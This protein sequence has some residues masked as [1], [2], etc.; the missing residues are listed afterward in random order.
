MVSYIGLDFETYGGT[1]LPKHGLHRYVNCPTFKPL[2]A[3]VWSDQGKH[4]IDLVQDKHGVEQ[5]GDLIADKGIA[6]HNAPFERA[7]LGSMGIKLPAGRF[8]DSAVVSRAVGGGSKLEVAAPQL[9]N[10]HKLD[11]GKHLIRKFSIPGKLQEANGSLEFDPDIIELYPQ[12]WADFIY[13]CS[14]DAQLGFQIVDKYRRSIPQ[15]EWGFN[16]LTSEMND[17][18]WYVDLGDVRQMQ[19]IYEIRARLQKPHLSIEQRDNLI[20]VIDLL[21]TKQMLGGSSLKKLATIEN[22]VGND[23]RLHDSYLHIGAGQTWRTSGK[24]VQMQNLKRLGT[25]ADM[26]LLHTD[27]GG[28][29]N[30]ALA[31]NLRQV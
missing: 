16:D 1:D 10:T 13:Y 23:G 30:D 24:G 5:L 18:G 4:E 3:C 11:A 2:I 9:L 25:P 27:M 7:V 20:Q 31:R 15:K 14:I 8:L 19:R 22:M 12:E 21:L 6:A 28:W 29:D 17:N 26:D